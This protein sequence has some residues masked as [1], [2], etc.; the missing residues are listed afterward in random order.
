MTD[1]DPS[2]FYLREEKWV[3]NDKSKILWNPDLI[4]LSQFNISNNNHLVSFD[5]KISHNPEDTLN[6]KVKDFDLADLN[7]VLGGDLTMGGIVNINGTVAD[8][9][10]NIRFESESDIIGFVLNEE[11][12][13]DLHLENQWDKTTNSITMD[14]N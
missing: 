5:G 1:F 8:L 13:G 11:A 7:S 4:Q 12:V 10:D 2:F 9:Y 3:I 6:L 14:G